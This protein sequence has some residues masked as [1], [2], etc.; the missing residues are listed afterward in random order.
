MIDSYIA[1]LKTHRSNADF[2][3]AKKVMEG[4]QLAAVKYSLDPD[5][6]QVAGLLHNMAAPLK[7]HEMVELLM[8]H[9]TRLIRHI[10][11]KCYAKGYLIGP[12]SAVLALEELDV[13][14]LPV[15]DAIRGHTGLIKDRALLTR[16]LFIVA[17]LF[18]NDSDPENKRAV[19]GQRFFFGG[20][21]EAVEKAL[22]GRI[23]NDEKLSKSG[24]TRIRQVSKPSI[25]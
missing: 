22:R 7:S 13:R 15:L 20:K 25:F 6:A 24:P 9:D 1:Y 11:P 18:N 10:P 17:I 14:E 5:M 3:L 2:E 8:K 21:L 19:L 12:A 16:C 4:M 23:A